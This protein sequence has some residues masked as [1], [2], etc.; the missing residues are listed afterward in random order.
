M[1]DNL[2]DNFI[3][4]STIKK[5]KFKITIPNNTNLVEWLRFIQEHRN[6][7][8]DNRYLI[9]II[10][11]TKV[12][13]LQPFHLASLA[14]LLE[15]Y[16]MS[17][18]RI[19]FKSKRTTESGKFISYTKFNRYWKRFF[20]RNFCFTSEINNT[21]PIWKYDKTRI[22][23][24]ATLAENFYSNH[25]VKGKDMSVLRNSIVEALNNI[26]DHSESKVSGFISTQYYKAKNE[27]VI[28]IC[29]F[30]KGIPRTV[31]SYL[32]KNG[33]NKLSDCL[34]LS[35]A[36]EYGFSTRS[37]PQNR[38]FGL[39][40][41]LTNVKVTNGEIIIVSNKALLTKKT[42][43]GAYLTPILDNLEFS[44]PG[45]YLVIKLNTNYFRD[46]EEEDGT[47]M[48]IL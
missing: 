23:S 19:N 5:K 24:F 34:A 6:N 25:S 44:F 46:L 29:D 2:L 36:L 1:L 41:I 28:A 20:N 33:E 27:L 21:L 45:T 37:T 40:N 22:D 32:K 10:D 8:K 14:C 4:L 3:I 12:D 11:F 47:E 30:G 17:G 42:R 18:A 39:D 43:D 13:F 7:K 15:E 31:N 26:S 16:K 48:M 9:C 35:R 38:G